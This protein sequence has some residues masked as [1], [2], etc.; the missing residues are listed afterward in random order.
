MAKMNAYCVYVK[1]EAKRRRDRGET[2]NFQALFKELDTQWRSLSDEG[3]AWYKK[4]AENWVDNPP[5][6]KPDTNDRPPRE[7]NHE[8]NGSDR[9][10][11]EGTSG[12]NNPANSSINSMTPVTPKPRVSID[13]TPI[14]SD[15]TRHLVATGG[16]SKA[17]LKRKHEDCESSDSL[18]VLKK[19]RPDSFLAKQGNTEDRRYKD[20]GLYKMFNA[21]QNM[22]RD[23]EKTLASLPL[24]AISVNVMCKQKLPNNQVIFIPLEIGISSYSLKGGLSSKVFH[25]IIDAGELPKGYQTISMEHAAATHKITIPTTT[26]RY[27]QESRNDY[28]KIYKEIYDYT[29]PGERTLLVKEYCDMDQVTKSLEWLYEIGVED[30]TKLPKPNAFTFFTL[31]EYVL[32]MHS[33]VWQK[34]VCHPHPKAFL[35]YFMQ[36]ISDS[37]TFEYDTSLMCDYHRKDEYNT[38]WCAKSCC[39]RMLSNLESVLTEINSL[40]EFANQAKQLKIQDAL[41]QR[42]LAIQQATYYYMMEVEAQQ[43]EILAIANE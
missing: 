35:N 12:T 34:M 43:Q 40:Y 4:K 3:R 39:L 8:T 24:H 33:L 29:K 42:M 13:I 27:P 25:A 18:V 23:R 21:C 37:S 19:I 15:T 28:A 10:V 7:N 26:Q 36:T 20:H 30:G 16:S 9:Q 2:V 31:K 41:E 5:P 22:V 6:F 11:A 32:A 1:I 17:I 38:K 14:T